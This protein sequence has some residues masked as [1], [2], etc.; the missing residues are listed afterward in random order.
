MSG[1]GAL[2][3]ARLALED[4]K[5]G[6]AFRRQFRSPDGAELEIGCGKGRF[7]IHSAL[8]LPTRDF[9]GIERAHRF[10]R[11]ALARTEKRGLQNLKL[12]RGDA[13]ELLAN[14][15]A[16][17]LRAVH[18]LFPDPWPK[19]R[20]RKRRLFREEF[21]QGVVRVLA[22]GG[23]LNLATDHTEYFTAITR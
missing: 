10:Y 23:F 15:P 6:G 12:V 4:L 21:V 3:T 1:K 8:T 11:V 7:L 14:I 13:R 9:L 2:Y 19:R 22:E 5:P 20:H 17:S 16:S 18:V